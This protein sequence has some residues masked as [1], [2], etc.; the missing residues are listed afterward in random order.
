MQLWSKWT[1]EGMRKNTVIAPCVDFVLNDDFIEHFSDLRPHPEENVMFDDEAPQ[2]YEKF[3]HAW[4]MVRREQPVA[5]CPAQTPLPG[6]RM[7]KEQRA[8]IFFVHPRPRTLAGKAASRAAPHLANLADAG[9][10]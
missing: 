9:P 3:R 6:K 10:R 5:P 8:V 4:L 1:S 7:G 2:G